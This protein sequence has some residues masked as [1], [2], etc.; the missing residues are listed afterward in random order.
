MA[1]FQRLPSPTG[2]EYE[3]VHV[4]GSDRLFFMT[5]W[6]QSPRFLLLVFTLNEEDT[7]RIETLGGLLSKL[8]AVIN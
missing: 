3:R 6:F 2:N 7:G 1:N 8:W 4:I 5:A